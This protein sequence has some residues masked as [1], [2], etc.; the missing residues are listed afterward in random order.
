[1]IFYHI[2]KGF[3]SENGGKR[4]K[5]FVFYS[6]SFLP[7]KAAALPIDIYYLYIFY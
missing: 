1:M 4:K 3:A 5:S 2:L 6:N 7:E